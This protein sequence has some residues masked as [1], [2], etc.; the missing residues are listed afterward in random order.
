VLAWLA[1][2]A[3]SPTESVNC[4]TDEA[5]RCRLRAAVSVHE[6]RSRLP[7]AIPADEVLIESAAERMVPASHRAHL[8]W[9]PAKLIA[10][11]QGIGVSAAA[12]ATWQ[13][14]HHPHPEQGYR[15]CLGLMRLARQYT[16]QRLEGACT[17]ALAIRS[18]TY[19]SVDNILKSGLDRQPTNLPATTSPLP[20][21]ENVRGPDYYH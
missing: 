16:P 2:C 11:T 7:C 21:H 14:E 10:W 4:A 13:L 19:R 3:L 8:E 9:T 17:R 12:L 1:E 5:V 6:L 18:P 15:A 20:G